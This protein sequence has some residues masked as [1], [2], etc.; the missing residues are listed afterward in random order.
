MPAPRRIENVD[1]Y[2][3]AHAA[4][5]AGDVENSLRHYEQIIGGEPEAIL[6]NE[7]KGPSDAVLL[8]ASYRAIAIQDSQ[9]KREILA[10]R[11]GALRRQI[12]ESIK[13]V[14]I[15]PTRHLR[16]VV[17]RTAEREFELRAYLSDVTWE[18]DLLRSAR[19]LARLFGRQSEP[20]MSHSPEDG[21]YKKLGS[22]WAMEGKLLRLINI[23]DLGLIKCRGIWTEVHPPTDAEVIINAFQEILDKLDPPGPT[24]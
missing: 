13:P 11:S 24:N 1:A 18:E 16:G 5:W 10:L 19:K 9:K 8:A 6:K 2:I 20:Y 14:G 22:G 15:R 21:A 4:E 23:S 12:G 17:R 7:V 3:V